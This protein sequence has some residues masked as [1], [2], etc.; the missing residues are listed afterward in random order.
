M[1]VGY[2]FEESDIWKNLLKEFQ[3][4]GIVAY[5]KTNEESIAEELRKKKK[6]EIREKQRA[7]KLEN[8]EWEA[9][10]KQPKRIRKTPSPSVY[11]FTKQLSECCSKLLGQPGVYSFWDGDKAV[12]VGMS[13]DLGTR[14][15]TSVD[16]I[17]R[18]D[19]NRILSLKYFR[20]ETAADAAFWE[21]YLM[22]KLKPEFNKEGLHY[23]GLSIELK[24][25][26]EF[27]E[28]IICANP[29]VK[30]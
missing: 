13:I 27:S 26:P 10:H 30:F 18:K 23:D 12:Y 7:K 28:P 19:I 8:D 6:D 21:I 4:E 11:K 14:I 9:K 16:P 5:R 1:G 3:Q 15:K 20:C 29:I 24:D 17:L 2:S 25:V 22:N